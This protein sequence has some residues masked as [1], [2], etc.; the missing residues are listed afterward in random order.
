MKNKKYLFALVPFLSI[1]VTSCSITDV[2]GSSKA[3]NNIE[4][5]IDN[6]KLKGLLNEGEVILNLTPNG[7]YNGSKGQLL[8]DY[9]VENGVIFKGDVGDNL[10]TNKEV[11]SSV[12]NNV[13]SSWVYLDDSGEL[14][15][16]TT[17]VEDIYM[18][19]AYWKYTGDYNETTSQTT[20]SILDTTSEES[21]DTTSSS[22]SSLDSSTT[23]EDEN[24]VTLYFIDKEWWQ[25]GAAP[26]SSIHYWGEEG[27]S[28]W[29]GMRMEW[30]DYDEIAKTNLWKFDLDVSKYPNFMFVR[31]HSQYQLPDMP[32]GENADWGAKTINLTYEEGINCYTLSDNQVW[33]DPGAEVIK[34]YLDI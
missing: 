32:E 1:L 9:F 27:G 26:S 17:I 6:D 12:L 14:N 8:E 18:Y 28:E 7:L 19:H 4:Q 15:F 25:A 11:T 29:P 10:P 2:S 21:S 22:D 31:T 24:I 30:V 16:T 5:N 23:I 34:S 33:G 13:L 20:S 3:E